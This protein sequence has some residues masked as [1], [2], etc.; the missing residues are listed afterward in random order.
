ME[1]EGQFDFLDRMGGGCEV[2]ASRYVE[3]EDNGSSTTLIC[4]AGM[5]VLYAAMPRFEFRKTLGDVGGVYNFVWVRD[6]HR[7]CYNFAPDGS[8]DGFAFYARLIGDALA[9]L[10]STH[11]IAIGASGGGAAAFAF[12]GVL[13]IDQVIAF[14]PAFPLDA[15][16][17]PAMIR[18]VVLDWRKLLRAP[19]DYLEVLLVTLSGRYLWRRNCRLVG[20]ERVADILECYLRKPSPP[21]ATVFYSAR[22]WPDTQQVLILRDIPSITLKPVDSGRHNC[23][24]ELKKRG[25]FGAL[26][27]GEILA[28]LEA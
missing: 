16:S 20:Q 1:E 24:G 14:N 23:M 11:V 22:C 3:L 17:R 25:E 13:P 6:V 12:S 26:I 7:S 10:S 2:D 15:Y 27:H 9:Q 4:F 19:G 8:K 21:R 18:H 28:G 5:A